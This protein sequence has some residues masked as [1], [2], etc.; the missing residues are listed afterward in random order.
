M[1]K[2]K[3]ETRKVELEEKSLELSKAKDKFLGQLKLLSKAVDMIIEE[4]IKIQAA[5]EEICKLLELDPVE[6]IKKFVEK[7]KVDVSNDNI[8]EE[9]KNA[10]DKPKEN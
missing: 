8:V 7:Q 4:Q 5:Y 3:I 6:E 1:E 10:E 2:T 9:T